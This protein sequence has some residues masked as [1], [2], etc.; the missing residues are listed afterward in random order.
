M[1]FFSSPW[2]EKTCLERFGDIQGCPNSEIFPFSR[3]MKLWFID[4]D[5]GTKK[6]S[7]SN[8]ITLCHTVKGEIMSLYLK[9]QGVKTDFI[10]GFNLRPNFKSSVNAP[11]Y[12]WT[13]S[14]NPN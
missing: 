4:L 7:Y 14:N 1:D 6:V 10:K 3:H 11:N 12:P 5:M 9:F 13:T 2:K 8:N